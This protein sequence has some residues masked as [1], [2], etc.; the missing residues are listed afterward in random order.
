[1]KFSAECGRTDLTR[2]L[3]GKVGGLDVHH[4]MAL[5]RA[6]GQD[7]DVDKAFKIL[8]DLRSSGVQLDTLVYNSVLDVCSSAGD[9]KRARNLVADMRSEGIIDIVSYNTLL[10]GCGKCGDIRGAKEVIAEMEKVGIPPNDVSYNCLI[11]IAASSG[12]FRAAWETI[13][14]MER[15]GIAIDHYTV[16]TMMKA[17]KHGQTSRG[18]VNRVMALLDRHG[19]DVCCEEVLL[20]TTVEACIKHCEHKRLA[21]LVNRVDSKK[22]TIQLA[23]H[24]YATLIRACG[25][26]KRV[27]RCRELWT[28]MTEVQGHTPNGVSLGCILDAL[29]CNGGVVEGVKL[30]RKWQDRVKVNT[31]LYSTLIKGFANISDNKRAEEMWQELC[32]AGLPLNTMVYNAIIDAHARSGAMDRVTAL[33]GSMDAAGCKPDDISWS[34]VAK[35]YCV[36]GELDR[37]L[38]VFHSL[39]TDSN[40]NTVIIYNTILDGCVRHNRSDL[41]D[42]MLENMEQW[43]IEPTNFTLGI[44]VKM[45][46]RRRQ[47]KRALAAV[48][49]FP[50]RYGFTP[51]GPV[52]TCLLF[53]CLR[54]EALD[55]ALAVFQTIRDSG[56]PVDSKIF[57]AL[58]NNCTRAGRFERAVSLVEEAYGLAA[59]SG[60]ARPWS[61]AGRVIPS[62]DDLDPACL[63]QLL[64][65]LSKQG[66]LQKVGVPLLQKMRSA[67][68]AV[69]PRLMNM[70]LGAEAPKAEAP[71]RNTK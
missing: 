27:N 30:L 33:I 32:T 8:A 60:E 58:I 34:M 68:V 53:A 13:E 50:K 16:S 36:T 26:L 19:I 35:G 69:S 45:W 43:H 64:K 1:M 22:H 46:G 4:H 42:K 10:K 14:T 62:G 61:K 44:V 7:K 38:E 52:Q 24:S 5:I 18:A 49:T 21:E 47:L 55:T 37:A 63:E 40:A 17:L 31:V 59:G 48:E 28:E 57:T 56:I 65:L 12:D 11:N 54:N 6:A 71:W 67:K 51:N 70:S 3:F 39:P 66:I 9:I 41:A 23:Q 20:N 2:E 25:I 15:K 29:V